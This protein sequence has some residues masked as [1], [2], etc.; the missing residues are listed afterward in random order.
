MDDSKQ[1]KARL[2][3]VEILRGAGGE[4]HQVAGGDVPVLTTQQGIPVV[5][6]PELAQGGRARADVARGL[7]LS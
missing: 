1:N 4:T 5:G 3:D 2:G 7:S 6:R